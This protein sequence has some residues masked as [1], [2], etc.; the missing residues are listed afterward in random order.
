MSKEFYEDNNGI[1]CLTAYGLI[2][3]MIIGLIIGIAFVI[4]ISFVI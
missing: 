2:K 4:V 1:P 3:Y